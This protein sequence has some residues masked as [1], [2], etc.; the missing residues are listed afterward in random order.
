MGHDSSVIRQRLFEA[1]ERRRERFQEARAELFLRLV[2][3]TPGLR[4]L[5]LGGST[6]QFS[7][8]LLRRAD[9]DM[10]VADIVDTSRE[11]AAAGLRFVQ[12]EETPRLPFEDGQF[13]IVLANSVIEHVT[14]PKA[15]SARMDW[16]EAEWKRR[17]QEGQRQFALEIARVG[18]GY[19]VQT[20]HKRFP[21]D[22]HLWLPF[23]NWL[24]HRPLLRLVA[25]TNRI[26]IKRAS[27]VDWQ[28]LG[29]EDMRRYF[30]DA[31]LHIER[32]LGLPKSLIAFRHH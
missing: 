18:R 20:P 2:Q 6:G 31:E 24:P 14:V 10:T 7:R 15:D 12:L 23:T 13:D 22:Q 28:L 8:R 25:L 29:P 4:V 9:L 11:C 1:V 17:A 21:L 26:W 32:A 16:A 5:D 3:P 30:P 19:F 27:L